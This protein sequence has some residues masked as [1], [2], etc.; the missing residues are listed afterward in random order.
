MVTAAYRNHWLDQSGDEDIREECAH[1]ATNIIRQ[2]RL[3]LVAVL[4]N[5]VWVSVEE[6]F[7]RSGS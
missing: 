7:L 2:S 4:S 1:E 3:A 5:G 6:S